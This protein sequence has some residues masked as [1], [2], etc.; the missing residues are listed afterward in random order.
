MTASATAHPQYRH[1]LPG[2][3]AYKREDVEDAKRRRPGVSLE[4]YAESR[5]LRFIDTLTVAGFEGPMPSDSRLQWNVIR[6]ERDGRLHA[7]FHH[8]LPV[9]W[10]SE[11]EGTGPPGVVSYPY[12]P[13]WGL[14]WLIE[15][16]PWVGP[17]VESALPAKDKRPPAVGVPTT[18][19]AALVPEAACV[20]D[21]VLKAGRLEPL[22]APAPSAEFAG[23]LADTEFGAAIRRLT[24]RAQCE[25][26]LD[27]GR[28][29][30]RV[31]GYLAEEAELDGLRE[32][33]AAAARALAQAAAPEHAPQPF[34]QPLPPVRWPSGS[35]E[36]LT[37][38][39]DAPDD[40]WR[41]MHRPPSP[42]F[43]QL[44]ALADRHGAELED[45]LGFHRAF[46]RAPV[47]GVT[48]AVMRMEPGPVRLVW[49]AEKP[50]TTHNVGFNVVL[51]PGPE[52]A[53]EEPIVAITGED[54]L[55]YW[56]V[57]GA[58][59]G[60]WKKRVWQTQEE[61]LGD[62]EGLLA[63]ARRLAVP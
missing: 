51:M 35:H 47:P 28:L 59:L 49:A 38:D 60:V 3:G 17:I 34:A 13:K 46:P 9:L 19:A 23:R 5:G 11:E 7:V 16:V 41:N 62:M 14:R 42:W 1:A 54:R 30:L 12:R 40:I 29:S 52:A 36:L 8:T 53:C 31:D 43:A 4:G 18:V 58:V 45:Q 32:S 55:V 20:P 33:T 27:H 6:E 26:S 24:D 25:V 61:G 63:T 21:F 48:F 39:A 2:W 37:S 10:R 57:R 22:S 50:I 56:A 15:L 44:R